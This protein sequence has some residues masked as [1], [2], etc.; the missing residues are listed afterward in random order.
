MTFAFKAL[1][2]LQT[3]QSL[4]YK[5][6]VFFIVGEIVNTS[7]CVRVLY[8][9]VDYCPFFAIESS[10]H[11]NWLTSPKILMKKHS[12]SRQSRQNEL[13]HLKKKKKI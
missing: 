3:L 5:Y 13:I 10:I 8:H 2:S 1:K 11:Y 7:E 6:C 4:F 12:L 9:S